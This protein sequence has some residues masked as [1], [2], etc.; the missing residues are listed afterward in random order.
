MTQQH[1]ISLTYT[2]DE[3]IE[4]DGALTVLERLFG[5]LPELTPEQRRGLIKMGDKSEAFCR[6]TIVVLDQHHE[7]LPPNFDLPEAQSDLNQRDRLRPRLQRLARLS[8]RGADAD[9]AL[10]SDILSACLEGYALLKIAGKGAGLE[11]LRQTMSN[12]LA[13]GAKPAAPTVPAQT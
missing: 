5:R 13:R 11:A 9:T 3:F 2:D 8:G 12:R 1:V 10:G 6:Q 7:V 4:M